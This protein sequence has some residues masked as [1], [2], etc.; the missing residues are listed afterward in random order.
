MM[1]SIDDI[2]IPDTIPEACRPCAYFS[3]TGSVDRYVGHCTFYERFTCATWECYATTVRLA[4][5][6]VW[7]AEETAARPVRPYRGFNWGAFFLAPLWL[8]FHGRLGVALAL[9][10]LGAAGSVVAAASAAGA[11]A[12][13]A[14]E[15]AVGSYYGLNAN[16]IAWEERGYETMDDLRRSQWGWNVAGVVVGLVLCLQGMR[17]LLAANGVDWA[18]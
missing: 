16:D 10:I 3:R 17:L 15:F 14:F 6:R 12:V 2:R 11:I 8:L 4:S 5:D 1:Q 9:V 18:H 7:R 13:L